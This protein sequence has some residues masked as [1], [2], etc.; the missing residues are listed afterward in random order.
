MSWGQSRIL[1]ML[2]IGLCF[3]GATVS[4]AIDPEEAHYN[5]VV[6]LYN[7]GQC[8]AALKKMDER[9]AVNLSDDMRRKYQYARGLALEKSGR[10][11]AAR[12]VYEALIQKDPSSAE[13][14]KARL[15][16]LFMDA[17][18]G[19][20]E[21]VQKGYAEIR[22]DALSPAERQDLT[23]LAAES[24]AAV[25][26]T[27]QAVE[28][29]RQALAAGAE[30]A[31]IHPKLFGLLYLAQQY[32]DLLN[33]SG[34]ALP[35]LP[36]ELVAMA[37][38]EAFLA[39]NRLTE[40]EAEARKVASGTDYSARAAFTLAQS[41]IRQNRLKEAAAPLEAA[42]HGMTHPAAPPDAWLALAE[43]RLSNG[44]SA[45]AEKAVGEGEKRANELSEGD[46]PAFAAR[47]AMLRVRI[48][49]NLNDHRRLIKAVDEARTHLPPESMAEVLYARLYALKQEGDFR[50]IAADIGRD[51]PAFKGKPQEGPAALIAGE[52]L[53]RLNQPVEA[54]A[55]LDQ[56]LAANPRT[57]EAA[58]ARL[59]LADMA[60][61]KPDYTA[62][63]GR[64]NE[65][66]AMPE[67]PA[68][69]GPEAFAGAQYNRAVAA[70]KTG[71]R[72]AA[73]DALNRLVQAKANPET[74]GR[75][76]I[77]L[78]Q[79]QAETGDFRKAA[80]AWQAALTMPGVDVKDLRDRTGR[81]LLAA[82]DAAGAVAEFKALAGL[83][84]GPDSL[85]IDTRA[86]WAR[87]Q[88][89]TG[90][91]AGAA[92]AY[93]GLY[94]AAG[95]DPTYAYECA[96]CHERVEQW[97]EAEQWYAKAV[98]HRSK[99]PA[100]YNQALDD[101]LARMRYQAGTGDMGL[102]YW[103]GKLGPTASDT[104][105]DAAIAAINRIAD[106]VPADAAMLGR[107]DALLKDYTPD[108]ARHYGI[109]ATLCRLL[110]ATRS[111]RLE[112]Q[113]ASLT[114]DFAAREATL[115]PNTWVT[116]VAPAM[117][118]FFHGEAQRQ[119][120]KPVEALTAYETVLAAY[121]FNEWPDA[122]ACGAAECYA[123]L[124]DVP[125][126]L[127]KFNEVVKS[128]AGATTSA[129]WVETAKKR[130]AELSQGGH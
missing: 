33:L 105:F 76:L 122:A 96:V 51:M 61:R 68:A 78:G 102:G 8:E 129:R 95:N 58:L 104:E 56:Y 98:P 94:Q 75:A 2:I 65:L 99:L 79:T 72:A 27:A 40:A 26:H 45:E 49:S 85:K 41:L 123:A 23:V 43:C 3:T 38:A 34:A 119:A 24:Q 28:L 100:E 48:A 9:E 107:F 97:A 66:L 127:E 25:G 110:A 52:A 39:L 118:F 64:L 36:P 5:V 71:D 77:L 90:D 115:P 124:G 62:A 86:A 92:T 6:T 59:E 128:T 1:F 55:V 112:P 114:A 89:A 125:T 126:A 120:G 60:L 37:R 91:A 31:K 42:I 30:A 113:A 16:I 74:T 4:Q 67:A 22:Q 44:Q 32:Q 73:V 15:A 14:Q 116:T 29:Y 13:S 7:K 80:A 111:N 70:L 21:A 84:G 12:P 117:L 106:T 57:A 46:R 87:A 50:Q 17:Q 121:P 108:Q 109:G 88:V 101:N 19:K 83:A 63:L 11:D 81:A 93:A 20:H 10:A 69:L 103:S 130:I 47:A 54:A 53:K 18:A 82:G 35:G